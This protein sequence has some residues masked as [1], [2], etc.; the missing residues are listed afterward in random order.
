M[1]GGPLA[2]LLAIA[3]GLFAFSFVE[4]FFHRWMFHTRI[5]LFAQGHRMHHER[6]WATTRCRSSCPAPCC[7]F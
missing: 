1:A 6:R 3:L 2:A 7:L 5:P 4:Y